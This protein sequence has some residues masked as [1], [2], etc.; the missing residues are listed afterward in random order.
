MSS[1]DSSSDCDLEWVAEENLSLDISIDEGQQ[2]SWQRW[3]VK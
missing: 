3:V 2:W 1:G